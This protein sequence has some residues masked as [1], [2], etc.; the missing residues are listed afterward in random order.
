MKQL[1][2]AS[3]ASLSLIQIVAT[4][5]TVVGFW[6]FDY[7]FYNI[8]L[9]LFAYFLY[10]GVGVS[11]MLHRYWCHRSFQFKSKPL[12]VIFS[13]FAL[14]AGRG[15][16]LGWVHVHREHH[17]YSDTPTDPHAPTVYGWKLFFPFLLNYGDNVNR[18]LIRD[19]YTS[20]QL[21]INRYYLLLILMWVIFLSTVSLE[22][23]YFG[24]FVPVALTQIMLNSFIYCGH[25]YGYRNHNTN[26][27]SRNLWPFGYFLWGEGWHNNHHKHAGKWTFREKW[28]EFDPI[29]HVV[30]L[31]KK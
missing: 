21:K 30:R 5:G 1:F 31:V 29:E 8:L 13:W 9:L 17:A 15:S 11:M 19:L 28:W 6:F 10:A 12:M 2:S 22:L 18:F 16:I 3:S 4:L 26:D 25:Q 14:M 7:D 23:V 27:D 24:W 20:I